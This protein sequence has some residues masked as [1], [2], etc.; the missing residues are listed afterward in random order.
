MATADIQREKFASIPIR[1]VSL[2]N[3]GRT[4]SALNSLQKRIRIFSSVLP[5]CRDT[6]G[7]GIS[8]WLRRE[9]VGSPNTVR[10]RWHRNSSS[11]MFVRT[12]MWNVICM[13]SARGKKISI[14][15]A[16]RHTK[17]ILCSMPR[18]LN[19]QSLPERTT[20]IRRRSAGR[21][22]R[23]NCLG[24]DGSRVKYMRTTRWRD[25]RKTSPWQKEKP[26]KTIDR[27]G[28]GKRIKQEVAR[29]VCA[30]FPVLRK[31]EKKTHTAVCTQTQVIIFH[32]LW[33]PAM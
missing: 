13:E 3:V 29:R 28:K 27:L 2:S 31:R 7:C 15:T 6:S 11:S 26:M 14:T 16:S 19:R 9:R 22:A 25:G 12:P 17:R 21:R 10:S 4:V 20:P 24:A 23:H 1:A 18:E 30:Y 32:W 5:I 33:A 8:N